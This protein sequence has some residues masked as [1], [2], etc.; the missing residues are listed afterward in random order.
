MLSIATMS[1]LAITIVIA[2]LL[3]MILIL[4]MV[5]WIRPRREQSRRRSRES[6]RQ[7]LSE[8]P[9]EF[10]N[11]SEVSN[12]SNILVAVDD[13]TNYTNRYDVI[14]IKSR[15]VDRTIS[16]LDLTS[17]F[18]SSGAGTVTTITNKL[19]AKPPRSLK[20]LLNVSYVRRVNQR[21]LSTMSFI[22]NGRGNYLMS[23]FEIQHFC[24]TKESFDEQSRHQP[25]W[26]REVALRDRPSTSFFD[27]IFSSR[28]NSNNRSELFGET[29][30]SSQI[31]IFIPGDLDRETSGLSGE[32]AKMR[33]NVMKRQ[34]NLQS[35]TDETEKMKE[36]ASQFQTNAKQLKE[37]FKTKKWFQL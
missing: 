2:V 35:C 20:L 17:N 14:L 23:L 34:E 28:T 19:A 5:R 37:K 27:S 15:E 7:R 6:K 32:L 12:A 30:S 22:N 9:S 33:Q 31:A 18:H 3:T 36:S 26:I 16:L 24:Y 1:V 21:I 25:K 29:K 13:V 4:L 10:S 8:N 11:Y